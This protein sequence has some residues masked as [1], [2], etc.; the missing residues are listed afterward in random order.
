[1]VREVVVK[2]AFGKEL[3]PDGTSVVTLDGYEGCQLQ[4]PYCFQF[5]QKDW[6][7]EIRVRTNIGEV[8]TDKN[9]IRD[10]C[11]DKVQRIYRDKIRQSADS[12]RFRD[13]KAVWRT[14]YGNLWFG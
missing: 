7:Q 6:G 2:E 9:D 12:K 13:S 1:M 14:A 10:S 3:Q 5:N 8:W 4:C 11:E